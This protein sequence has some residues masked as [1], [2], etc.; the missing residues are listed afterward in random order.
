MI[1]AINVAISDPPGMVPSLFIWNASP[2]VLAAYAFHKSRLPPLCSTIR[3]MFWAAIWSSTGRMAKSSG[4][5][6]T[7]SLPGS[8]PVDPLPPRIPNTLQS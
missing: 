7:P 1:P 6:A 2:P 4:V 5:P 8:G 3:V